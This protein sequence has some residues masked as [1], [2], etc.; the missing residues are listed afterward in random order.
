MLTMSST[1]LTYH[2]E[3]SANTPTYYILTLDDESGNPVSS[4]YNFVLDISGVKSMLQNCLVEWMKTKP[5]E[6]KEYQI[7]LPSEV[8]TPDGT[9]YQLPYTVGNAYNTLFC[10]D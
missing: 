6:G 10:Y 1:L 9:T 2:V 7:H 4:A 5:N 8:P 3:T